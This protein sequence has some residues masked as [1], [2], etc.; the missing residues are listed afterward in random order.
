[1]C[2][3]RRLR[4]SNSSSVD[5]ADRLTSTPWA[6]SRTQPLNRRLKRLEARGDRANFDEHRL[7]GG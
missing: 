4:T 6:C 5:T 7:L 1:M 3:P 2:Q